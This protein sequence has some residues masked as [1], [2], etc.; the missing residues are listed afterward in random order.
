MSALEVARKTRS[1]KEKQAALAGAFSRIAQ[2]EGAGS[3]SLATA[4]RLVLGQ[5]LPPASGRTTGVGWALVADTALEVAQGGGDDLRK[6]SAQAGDL[7][8]G[9]GLLLEARNHSGAGLSLAEAAALFD[10][11]SLAEGRDAKHAL[12]LA[13]LKKATPLESRYLIKAL[14]GELRIGVQRGLL[15]EGIA[16]AFGHTIAALRKAAQVVS[17]VGRLAQLAAKNEL[18]QTSFQPGEPLAF[19]LATPVEQVKEPVDPKR[20]IAEDKLDGI[21]VQVQAQGGKVWLFARG[22]GEV[23]RSFP[24]LAAAFAPLA[25]PLVLDGEIVAVT[26]DGRARPFQALQGRLG[27][28]NPSEQLQAEIPLAVFAYDV[29]VDRGEVL[30]EQPW[31]ARRERLE[32]VTA[33]LANPRVKLNP[34]LP[35]D[36]EKDL[37]AQL[38]AYF[39][40]ARARGNEGLVLK[41]IDA[42]YDAGR[43]GS[44]WRKVKRALATLDVVVTRAEWGHGKRTGV[45]SDY[46]FA[47]W[48][49]EK[50][51]EIGKAYS[52]LT[53]AEIA[54]MTDRFQRITVERRGHQHIVKPEVVLEVAFD[55]LQKSSRHSSGFALRFPRIARI[56]DDKQPH[57]ADT[58]AAAQALWDA[59]VESGHREE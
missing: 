26:P 16:A 59:Q 38:D 17:D 6:F 44:A 49:G 14:L 56:R 23:T 18:A 7:G 11:L 3:E 50:L 9:V 27:R 52:G 20:F 2:D 51:V 28:V 34:V 41:Q 35:L 30:L 22:Q 10:A 15:E 43:R 55:G 19:M 42:P 40:Q 13:A 32:K 54:M 39:A 29:M 31:T 25:G 37:A 8:D 47:V 1:K 5:V 12:L 33:A 36:A 45:L 24:E 48:D 21:R 46:T 4:A 57:E 58:L 53:D